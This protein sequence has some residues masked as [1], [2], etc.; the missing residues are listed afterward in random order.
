MNRETA[1]F[2]SPDEHSVMSVSGPKPIPIERYLPEY[3]VIDYSEYRKL[4][5]RINAGSAGKRPI[6]FELKR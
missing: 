5:R 1:Y 2:K 4:K 3:I 6:Q